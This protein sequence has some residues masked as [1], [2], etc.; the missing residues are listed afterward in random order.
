MGGI[1]GSMRREKREIQ[2]KQMNKQ[3]KNENDETSEKNKNN[4]DNK[5]NKKNMSV[6]SE[7]N[8]EKNSDKNS[9]E[10]ENITDI[11]INYISN[12][13]SEFEQLFKTEDQ[14][15]N[16]FDILLEKK[17]KYNEY[18]LIANDTIYLSTKLND[19]ISDIFPN[20][21]NAEVTLVYLGLD[22]SDDVKAEYEASFDVLGTP[23]FN[24]GENI[25]VLIY[26]IKNNNF[27]AEIL[28]KKILT[29]FSNLSSI[30]NMKNIL[31]I[32]G[33]D[34]NKKNS[35]N[36]NPINLFY[37]IDLLNINKIEE[38]PSLNTPR[39]WHSMIY[40]P[41]KYIFII[42]GGTLDV[43][44]YDVKKK[45]I[46]IDSKLKE[47]RN[48]STLF[49]MN[50]SVLYAFCGMSPEG[51]FISTVEKCNL[52]QKERS[53]SYV[54]YTT[55]D[56]TL[57]EDCYYI[58]QF[59]SDNSLILFAANEGENNEFS[60][61]LFDVE[62]EENPTISYY[63]KGEKITDVVME[64]IFHPVGNNSFVMI[65]NC[66]TLAKI[67]KVDDDMR[68]NVETFPGAMRNLV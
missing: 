21:E 58:G 4:S 23:L 44:L 27:T 13:K 15:S 61:I 60:N 66:V 1:C 19:K 63:E 8:S 18:D 33:G 64:K 47:I 16:L 34:E 9:E 20:T 57:F 28:E 2:A 59:F 45:E 22:I 53:W 56:N 3:Q 12:G 6:V 65:P 41:K 36:T 29:K 11:I 46:T 39:C 25:G 55:A 17:S 14:I 54:N 35:E 38:L 31:F 37:S 32:S 51:S 5:E 7:K 62:D 42:G 24:L 48:E 30:C 43:E 40:I 50:N 26:H 67:Y 52:R 10:K 49:I 68:L